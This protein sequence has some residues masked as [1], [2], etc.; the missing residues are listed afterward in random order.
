MQL[1]QRI[2]TL[3]IPVK[4]MF[5]FVTTCCSSDRSLTLKLQSENTT[6]ILFEILAP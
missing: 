1:L 5:L 4:R 2:I 6:F 3:Q